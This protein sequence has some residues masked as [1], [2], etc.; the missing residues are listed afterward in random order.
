MK[1]NRETYDSVMNIAAK[2][3]DFADNIDLYTGVVV[4]YGEAAE[5]WLTKLAQDLAAKA[6]ESLVDEPVQKVD[7]SDLQERIREAF[8]KAQGQQTKPVNNVDDF[9]SDLFKHEEE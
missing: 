7:L 2:V 6:E 8:R 5:A 1:I 3:Q 9:L 4:E